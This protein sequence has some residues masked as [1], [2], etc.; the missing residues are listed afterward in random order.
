MKTTLK[1]VAL[2][3][4]LT[5]TMATAASAQTILNGIANIVAAAN[6]RPANYPAHSPYVQGRT[7]IQTI[8]G[9]PGSYPAYYP[10]RRP[11]A[12]AP[13]P[14]V[15][16]VTWNQPRPNYPSPTPSYI[17]HQ[18]STLQQTRNLNL[19]STIAGTY[20]RNP[21]QNVYHWGTLVK[22]GTAYR[23]TAGTGEAWD[24]TLD[25]PNKRLIKHYN[26]ANGRPQVDYFHLDPDQ[27]GKVVGFTFRGVYFS[28]TP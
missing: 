1:I 5:A 28:R 6:Q 8:Q 2:T 9:R 3:I 24:L 15:N 18:P 25:L 4:A 22:T 12:P 14:Y 19:L 16:P 27:D 21:V 13:S 23:L 26:D 11:Y 20:Q 7:P 17:R 10:S